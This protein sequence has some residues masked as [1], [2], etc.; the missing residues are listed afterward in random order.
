M[1]CCFRVG[2]ENT[3]QPMYETWSQK[4]KNYWLRALY[5]NLIYGHVDDVAALQER[6]DALVDAGATIDEERSG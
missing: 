2:A 6:H 4:D 5:W 1:K 3:A